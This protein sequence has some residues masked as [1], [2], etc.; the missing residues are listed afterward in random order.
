MSGHVPALTPRERF[1]ARLAARPL[2]ADGAMGTLLF[3]RGVPQRAS[4][5]ELAST[6]PELVTTT[7]REYLEAGAELIET[8][9]LGANR[10]RLAPFGLAPRAGR[11][12]RRAAQLAREAREV[13]GRDALVGG[14]IGPLAPVGPELARLSEEDARAAFREQ[15]DGL[16]EGGIDVVVLETFSD[17]ASLLVALEVARAASDLPVV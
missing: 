8:V 17:L 16:L 3:S 11:L 15:L 4:L 7:H 9:T 5:D 1:R 2:L 6:R 14:S 10:Y 13:S 12:N